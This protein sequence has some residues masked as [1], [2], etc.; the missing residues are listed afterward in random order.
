VSVWEY[1]S[2][3]V[4]ENENNLWWGDYHPNLLGYKLIANEIVNQIQNRL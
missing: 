3:S 1:G 2:R 4:W